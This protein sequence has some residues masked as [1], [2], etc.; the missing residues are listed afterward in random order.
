MLNFTEEQIYWMSLQFAV[1]TENKVVYEKGFDYR[2]AFF[3]SIFSIG[4]VTVLL[5]RLLSFVDRG[6]FVKNATT[7]VKGAQKTHL[8]PKEVDC[9]REDELFTK[10][11]RLSAIFKYLNIL[12]VELKGLGDKNLDKLTLLE[13]VIS[14]CDGTDLE[15][16]FFTQPL[17]IRA[18]FKELKLVSKIYKEVCEYLRENSQ[19]RLDIKILGESIDVTEIQKKAK[20]VLDLLE[21]VR[22]QIKDCEPIII[23]KYSFDRMA[24]GIDKITDDFKVSKSNFQTKFQAKMNDIFKEFAQDFRLPKS[25]S[26]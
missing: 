6:E 11:L 26:R 18:L 21:S 20:E 4:F 16:K 12:E 14:I 1:P 23:K 24:D 15:V 9:S 7:A 22:V 17:D 10:L 13:R 8:V 19:V 2:L 25:M 3:L 5:D